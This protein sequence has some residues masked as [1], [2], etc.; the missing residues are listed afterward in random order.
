VEYKNN[1]IEMINFKNETGN[2]LWWIVKSTDGAII[3]YG[4]LEDQSL[5]ESGQDVYSTY[6]TEAEWLTEL[7]NLG[8]V[9][10]EN[11]NS[12]DIDGNLIIN[13]EN[14]NNLY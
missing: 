10:E 12:F 14:L 13:N 1:K 5:L 8:V 3:H 9:I 2:P 7:D 11:K 6:V 4:K